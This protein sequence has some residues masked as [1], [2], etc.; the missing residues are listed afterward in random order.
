MI[1]WTLQGSYDQTNLIDWLSASTPESTHRL[2]LCGNNIGWD[3]IEKGNER[4]GFFT[5]WLGA[6]I[7][8]A[9]V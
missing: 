9:H 8:R 1:R 4:Y 3:L 2:F 6:K 7:G 5:D